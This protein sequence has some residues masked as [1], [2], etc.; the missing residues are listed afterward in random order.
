VH[1]RRLI[2]AVVLTDAG[3][4]RDILDLGSSCLGHHLEER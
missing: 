3:T 4:S 1:V 2:M